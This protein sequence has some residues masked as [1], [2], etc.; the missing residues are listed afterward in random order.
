MAIANYICA[1]FSF[2]EFM[3]KVWDALTSKTALIVYS[4]IILAIILVLVV[5]AVVTEQRR[6]AEIKHNADRKSVV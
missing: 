4:A 3:G 2:T 1:A 5:R 6:T